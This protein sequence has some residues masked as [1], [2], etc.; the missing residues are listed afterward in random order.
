MKR[1][2]SFALAA[3]L[4]AAAVAP[5]ASAGPRERGGRGRAFAGREA[6]PR[7]R[8]ARKMAVRRH[9]AHKLL[10]ALELTDA[11]KQALKEAREGVAT[12][13][14]DLGAK[15]RALL[16]QARKGERTPE[17]RKAVCEQVKA[18]VTSARTAVEPSAT[19]FVASLSA[20]QK[21]KLAEKAKAHGKTF[22][23]AR[24]VKAIEGMLIAPGRH[25][26]GNR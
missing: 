22:E 17:S 3:T 2:L 6:G 23:E 11:Q 4:L 20:E 19:R 7:A 9:R 1:I 26:R 25:G 13:R 24:L 15:I 12:V 10:K 18:A 14:Q 16:E 8:L 21:A 5:V